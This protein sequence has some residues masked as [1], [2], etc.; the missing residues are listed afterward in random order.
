MSKEYKTLYGDKTK[1]ISVLDDG[2]EV[3]WSEPTVGNI[4]KY[5]NG[6]ISSDAARENEFFKEHCQSEY[7]LDEIDDLLAGTVS[8][9]INGIVLTTVPSNQ[10]EINNMINISRARLYDG[11]IIS[12]IED[13]VIAICKVF[14]SYTPD[15]LYKMDMQTFFNRL[16]LA[17]KSAMTETL[18]FPLQATSGK[19][20]E[21]KPVEKKKNV[22]P[23]T[24]LKEQ[25]E[26]QHNIEKPKQ[27]KKHD[28]SS[29]HDFVV[30]QEHMMEG[31][32]F[33]F[34]NGSEI[35]SKDSIIEKMI[36]ETAPH[37]QEYIDLQKERGKIEPSDIKTVSEQTEHMKTQIEKNKKEHE[38]KSMIN[39]SNE[40]KEAER[41]KKLVKQAQGGKGRKSKKGRSRSRK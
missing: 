28:D 11:S 23:T 6:Y 41:L 33:A 15:D 21:Q 24:N 5:L 26:K 25:Y 40:E 29:K 38:I 16:T 31:Q 13:C 36:K 39:K 37:Y 19:E 12:F 9:S 34:S 17:E 10:D 3:P 8:T 27:V 35:L 30:T 1:Y 4:L 20:E 2:I 14:T 7:L 32:H 22:H 18:P